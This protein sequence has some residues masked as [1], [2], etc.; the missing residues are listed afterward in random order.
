MST[1]STPLATRRKGWLTISSAA[2]ILG[3]GL[4]WHSNKQPE[5]PPAPP[6]LAASR[7]PPPPQATRIPV[8]RVDHPVIAAADGLLKS[9]SAAE[10]LEI[11]MLILADYQKALGGNPVGENEEITAALLGDNPKGLRFLPAGHRALDP[12]GRLCDRWGTP[13]FFHALASR[14]MAIR[15]AGPDRQPGTGDDLFTPGAGE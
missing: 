13:L 7:V 3:L 14:R 1:P 6:P 9:G 8:E 5:P 10:D 12:D 2:I 15:S 11:L 4:F